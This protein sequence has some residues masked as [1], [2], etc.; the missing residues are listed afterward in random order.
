MRWDLPKPLYDVYEWQ[1]KAL[2][3]RV[4]AERFFNDETGRR[5]DQRRREAAAKRVCRHCPVVEDCLAHAIQ[6]E[7]HGVW[8]G[9]TASERMELRAAGGRQDQPA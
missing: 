1:D 4:D 7:A 9:L 5:A 2:C 6:T 8:G 3:R